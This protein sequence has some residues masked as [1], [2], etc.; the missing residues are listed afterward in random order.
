ME[1]ERAMRSADQQHAWL[2][3][4]VAVP[5]NIK[6]SFGL[7]TL[8][9]KKVEVAPVDKGKISSQVSSWLPNAAVA[10]EWKG[11]VEQEVHPVLPLRRERWTESPKGLPARFDT[12]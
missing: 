7:N 9:A 8:N 2:G 5:T 4:F 12:H 6:D 3:S 10:R 1:P 11:F